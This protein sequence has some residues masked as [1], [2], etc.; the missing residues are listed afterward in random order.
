MR[1]CSKN[2]LIDI[3]RAETACN[4]GLCGGARDMLC[5]HM[6]MA[7]IAEVACNTRICHMLS[8]AV[9]LHVAVAQVLFD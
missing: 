3:N 4:S 1:S 6:P 2:C 5:S 9:E 7:I 8:H